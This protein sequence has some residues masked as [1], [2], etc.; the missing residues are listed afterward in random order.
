MVAPGALA[1]LAAVD[2]DPLAD[3]RAAAAVRLV[4]LGGVPHTVDELL[5]PFAAPVP[6]AAPRHDVRPALTGAEE[7]WWHE[8]EWS[9]HVCCGH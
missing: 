7:S 2:G 3:V 9:Q 4:L 1:D 6:A 8:P 5:A